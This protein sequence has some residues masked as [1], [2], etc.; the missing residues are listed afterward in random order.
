MT[1][2]RPQMLLAGGL[3]LFAMLAFLA[4]SERRR[5]GMLARLG[6]IKL[7]ERLSASINWRGRRWQMGLQLVALAL[8]V[9]AL[10]RP[11]WGSEVHEVEQ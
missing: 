6:E 9:V 4:W 7:V 11:Q 10:A 1:F 2:V 3:L 5:R 8:L